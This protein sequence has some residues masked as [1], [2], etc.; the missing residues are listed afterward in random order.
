MSILHA[1]A[2]MSE[3][4]VI[5][6]HG[7]I[8]WHLSEDFRWFKH[9]TMEARL[10][11]AENFRFN[12]QTFA[13]KKKPSLSLGIWIR[14]SGGEAYSNLQVLLAAESSTPKIWVCGGAEIYRQTPATMFGTLPDSRE[15]RGRGGHVHRAFR[16]CLHSSPSH[17]QDAR[18]SSR[19]LAQC[20]TK[21]FIQRIKTRI[22]AFPD[23]LNFVKKSAISPLREPL[24]FRASEGK[25][26]TARDSG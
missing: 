6:D 19:V 26:T 14:V 23:I 2:A 13:R 1:I 16:G 3:N 4:R 11:W 17:P 22:V 24:Y 25:R 21:P 18:I 9:K 8:P 10:S 5:G 7:K 15:A 20:P 12:R